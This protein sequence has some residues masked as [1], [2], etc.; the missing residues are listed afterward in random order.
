MSKISRTVFGFL[1]SFVF[2]VSLLA[3]LTCV[4]LSESVINH[5]GWGFMTFLSLVCLYCKSGVDTREDKKK[6]PNF[7]YYFLTVG[8][9]ID[10]FLSGFIFISLSFLLCSSIY[11]KEVFLIIFCSIFLVCIIGFLHFNSKKELASFKKD[12]RE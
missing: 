12:V 1:M 5:L 10:G 9:T 3:F 11:K 6:Y 8:R 7:K 2:T 4:V